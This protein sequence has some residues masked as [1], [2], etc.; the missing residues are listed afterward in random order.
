MLLFGFKKYMN[1]G[2][3]TLENIIRCMENVESIQCTDTKAITNSKF[4]LITITA[5]RK[6]RRINY[7]NGKLKNILLKP[8]NFIPSFQKFHFCKRR[9]ALHRSVF[10]TVAQ[11]MTDDRSRK[12]YVKVW[13]IRR[14]VEYEHFTVNCTT[15]HKRKENEILFFFL[16]QVINVSISHP[17]CKNSHFFG[18]LSQS[19]DFVHA[20]NSP[21]TLKILIDFINFLGANI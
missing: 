8:S 1:I 10:V 16:F 19:A 18:S 15:K 12:L 20:I 6:E 9:N 21:Q 17:F 4:C 5:T 13:I 11:W 2:W 3:E 14:R 7:C